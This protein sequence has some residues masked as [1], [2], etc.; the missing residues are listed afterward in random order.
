[1]LEQADKEELLN[2]EESSD[3]GLSNF[4]FLTSGEDAAGSDETVSES[5]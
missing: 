3:C 5:I 2:A 4:D 1:M